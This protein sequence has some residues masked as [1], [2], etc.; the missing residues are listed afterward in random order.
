M[1]RLPGGLR[2]LNNDLSPLPSVVA[3]AVLARSSRGFGHTGSRHQK[4]R[5]RQRPH[6]SPT[7]GLWRQRGAKAQAIGPSRGGQT[8]NIH[9]L[10]DV[11]ER[12]FAPHLTAGNV[13]DMT[14]AP[15]LLSGLTGARY[16]L[17]D[18][19]YDANALRKMLRSVSVVPVI[20]G[21]RDRCIAAR[22]ACVDVALPWRIWPIARRSDH[23]K[24]LAPARPVRGLDTL[25][26]CFQTSVKSSLNPVS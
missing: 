25:P 24:R 20:P 1:V 26:W 15:I 5:H 11:L 9:A 3:Q 12:P 10:T 18:K 7:L 8:S 21:R 23:G 2:P 17:A 19:G 22:T 6:Q 13:C 14:A 16:V 4:H